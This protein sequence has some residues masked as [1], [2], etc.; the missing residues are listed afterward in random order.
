MAK[1]CLCFKREN[2]FRFCGRFKTW[3]NSGQNQGASEAAIN[4][5]AQGFKY[6][7]ASCKFGKERSN[8]WT[9]RI[10]SFWRRV[11]VE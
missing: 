11:F 1:V 3:K 2:T 5:A 10:M 6:T 4:L 7:L 9:I 8:L